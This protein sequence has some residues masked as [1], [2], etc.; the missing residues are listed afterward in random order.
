MVKHVLF[1]GLLTLS[2]LNGEVTNTCDS[3]SV[4]EETRAQQDQDIGDEEYLV[5]SAT[6]F[7]MHNPNIK[8]CVIKEQTHVYHGSWLDEL[9]VQLFENAGIGVDTT[10]IQDFV[11]KN[12]NRCTIKNKFFSPESVILISDDEIPEL[13]GCKRSTKQ[14]PRGSWQPRFSERYPNTSGLFT[15]SRVGFN[16]ARTKAIVYFSTNEGIQLSGRG[17][18]V[19][20]VKQ[21]GHWKVKGHQ[22]VWIVM[23]D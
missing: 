2:I 12:Q 17:Y 4:N 3:L 7:H 6:L 18:L 20:L 13:I 9:V 21:H 22:T 16:A 1:S 11:T 5:Y 15:F 23:V 14:P 19:L 8:T 10:L